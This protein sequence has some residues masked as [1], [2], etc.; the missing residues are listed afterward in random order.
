ME[1]IIKSLKAQAETIVNDIEKDSKAARRR[2]RKATLE[3]SKLGKQY[4]KMSVGLDKA[5]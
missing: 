1:N 3:I 4:R 5:E 2:V